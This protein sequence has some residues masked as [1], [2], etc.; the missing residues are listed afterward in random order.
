MKKISTLIILVVL[1]SF[2]TNMTAFA[3]G[4]TP[5]I[6]VTMNKQVVK[7]DVSPYLS[8]DE[9]MVP[10]I[11]TAEAIGAKTEWDKTKQ[12]AWIH[13]GMAHAEF[14][15]G[16]SE[17][18]IHRDADFTGIPQTVKLNT[19]IKYSQG[20][21]F[22]PGKTTFENLGLTVSWDSKKRVLAM[23][24]E[25]T[26]NKDIHYTEL[27]KEEIAH[28]RLLNS[29]YNKNY[30]KAGVHSLKFNGTMYVL[31]S[32]GSKPTGGYT[33][34]I[35]RI[36]YE[37]STKAYVDAYVKA[38]SSDAMVT[39]VETYPNILLKIE[40]QKKL[41]SIR[42]EV[43]EL[44][45][46]SL[47]AKVLYD[48]LS[49]DNI[50]NNPKL[51]QWYSENNQ[52]QGIN[53]IKDGAYTYVLLGAGERPTG[54][55]SIKIDN[56]YYSTSDTVNI[57][58]IVTPPG[59]NVRVIMMITYPSMIL[60]IKSD[61]VKTVVGEVLDT[62]INGVTLDITNV[63]KMELY[64]LNQVKLRDITG[65]EKDEIMNS[66]NNAT[67]DYNPYIKMIAGKILKVTTTD[68]YLLTFSSYGSQTNVIVSIEKN[69]AA[70]AYHLLAPG[71]AKYIYQ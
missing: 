65:V 30:T 14:I 35:N 59:D 12:T 17:F 18:Y 9:V 66:F 60:R 68:G 6:K 40:D 19:P 63:T 58:A 20:S 2:V 64:D 41:R 50:I 33:I 62:K 24:G 8:K 28:M 47:P 37:S 43:Q 45:S 55:Y 34:G 67:I 1:M 10:V 57:R 39:Q 22:V 51:V 71:V 16:K 15:V 7:Y 54:G 32:A 70:K 53:Y 36:Y 29:W 46:D 38:P 25:N 27:S 49:Y 56:I 13:L 3:C 5:K 4:T 52:K 44:N 69:G 42:G 31:V 21:V 26:D 23:T 61:T 11:E 48:E